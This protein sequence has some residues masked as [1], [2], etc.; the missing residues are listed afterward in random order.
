MDDTSTAPENRQQ[1]AVLLARFDKAYQ[2]Q[3][4]FER[5][6]YDPTAAQSFKNKNEVTIAAQAKAEDDFGPFVDATDAALRRLIAAPAPDHKALAAKYEALE[7][8]GLQSVMSERNR[9]TFNALKLDALGYNGE[10]QQ[11]AEFDAADWLY[12]WTELGGGYVVQNDKVNLVS[13]AEQYCP[14]RCA[15]IGDL[16]IFHGRET[17][18]AHILGGIA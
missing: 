6:I 12:R 11:F 2:A 17:L 9:E 10:R 5:D 7:K 4:Q 1:F 8:T 14:Q 13:P 16:D 3:M 18:S 15:L